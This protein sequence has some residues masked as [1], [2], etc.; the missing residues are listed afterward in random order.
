M[1]V[2]R[3]RLK[4]D[5]GA[6]AAEFALVFPVL[7]LV[8]FAIIQLGS[9]L[10]LHNNMINTARETVRR[11]AVAELNETE[12]EQ[13]ATNILTTWGGA[14]NVDATE[15]DPA[16]PADRDVTVQITIPLTDAALIQFPPLPGG[17]L[18]ATAT[19]RREG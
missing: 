12:A 10:F 15:P 11:M 4:D 2:R 1:K 7:I 14:F 6:I 17:N 3:M 13:F 9:I 18:T 19:M 8:V 16:N 5:G